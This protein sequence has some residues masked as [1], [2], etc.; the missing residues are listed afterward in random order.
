M[1]IKG[2][3]GQLPAGLQERFERGIGRNH[4][5]W[6]IAQQGLQVD[7]LEQRIE[8]AA[9]T[10]STPHKARPFKLQLDESEEIAVRI[11][12]LAQSHNL[13]NVQVFTILINLGWESLA[14]KAAQVGA[15]IPAPAQ[16][17]TRLPIAQTV[18]A[19]AKPATAPVAQKQVATS[20]PAEPV[21][22]T[23]LS[24]TPEFAAAAADMLAQFG[25]QFDYTGTGR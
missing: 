8:I 19:T 5:L 13:A 17:Y 3:I 10:I 21:A 20:Q 23:S 24:D 4:P 11:K 22:D 7:Q 9:C 15:A 2:D 18:A 25:V 12:G 16:S 14:R 1:I 6:R